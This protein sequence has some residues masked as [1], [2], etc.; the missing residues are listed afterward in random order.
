MSK[1]F[2]HL[3]ID[4]E[5]YE[6]KDATARN[7]LSKKLNNY[8]SSNKI[9]V[10][11]ELLTDVSLWNMNNGWEGNVS[12]GFAHIVGQTGSLEYNYVF[13]SNK[14][15]IVEFDV[16]TTEEPGVDGPSNDFTVIV[17]DSEP[18]ITYQG[19]G[20]MHYVIAL[21][22]ST[23]GTLQFLCR[24]HNNPYL[25]ASSFIGTIKNISLKEISGN[26]E[27]LSI[28]DK[29]SNISLPFSIMLNK[30]QSIAIGLNAGISNYNQ[31]SNVYIGNNSGRNDVTGYFNT[32]VGDNTLSNIIN[33]SRNTAIGKSALA[34]LETGDRNT[35]IGTFA[36]SGNKKGRKN[37]AI[38]YDTMMNLLEG[39]ENIAI[40]N[41]A[42][43]SART[44]TSNIAIGTS[45][46]GGGILNGADENIAIGK[47]SLYFN[48]SGARNISIGNNSL[49]RNVSG[50]NN[51]AIGNGALNELTSL[52][53]MVAIG[54]D[55][56]SKVTTGGYSVVIGN[57][58]NHSSLT[59][60]ERSVAV[61]SV[62]LKDMVSLKQSVLMGY[63]IIGN[64]TKT[65]FENV[66]CINTGRRTMTLERDNFVNI[67]NA[68]V[69]DTFTVGS[70]KVGIGTL[71]PSARLHLA[72]QTAD[73]NTAP[74][75]LT[76]SETLMSYKEDGAFEYDGTHLYFTIGSERKTII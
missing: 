12:N 9:N 58:M 36:M 47:A 4:N 33:G 43:I 3:T 50:T 11:P 72:S 63:N 14:V 35:A 61:G 21:K 23:A 37:M 15:Y 39:E 26:L 25:E 30:N 24:K 41:Q 28:K 6:V 64:G 55:A 2:C 69:I 70:E 76:P 54:R 71:T 31:N 17:G 19:G 75:K 66:I 45:A 20:S 8:S 34:S 74:I 27:Q 67:A 73:S 42:L 1:C 62:L 13:D 56:I 51:I 46:I 7:E 53:G 44:S 18:I 38:G 59:T 52:K 5:S 22:P 68:L 57:D 32:G 10:G 16:E 29:D 48:V 49:Y 65:S 40:G 60:A